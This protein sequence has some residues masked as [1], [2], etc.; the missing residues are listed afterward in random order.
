MTADEKIRS[1]MRWMI[2]RLEETKV[3]FGP[4]DDLPADGERNGI[5]WMTHGDGVHISARPS[6]ADM[7]EDS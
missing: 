7:E 2:N 3:H 4:E 6:W 5:R 1:A